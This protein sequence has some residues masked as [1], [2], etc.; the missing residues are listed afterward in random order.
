M[1]VCIKPPATPSSRVGSFIESALAVH[2]FVYKF[3]PATLF[4][5]HG[6]SNTCPYTCLLFDGVVWAVLTPNRKSMAG[7]KSYRARIAAN[8]L[9]HSILH[10]TDIHHKA[11]PYSPTAATQT[12]QLSGFSYLFPCFL[13]TR[14]DRKDVRIWKLILSFHLPRRDWQKGPSWIE[15]DHP[16]SA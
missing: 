5:M 4:I 14:L 8:N 7:I 3:P 16:F 2:G 9:I 1:Y 13:F 12:I 15:A 11:P 6:L 10:Q